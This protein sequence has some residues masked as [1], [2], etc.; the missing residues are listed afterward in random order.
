[1][2]PTEEEVKAAIR[3]L[4]K[5]VKHPLVLMADTDLHVYLVTFVK[6]K[7]VRYDVCDG[8]PGQRT[9]ANTHRTLAAAIEDFD[10]VIAQGG[11]EEWGNRQLAP[12]KL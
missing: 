5:V 4:E 12:N 9:Y 1:M 3:T 11:W 6:N 10:N 2:K 7:S 8:I